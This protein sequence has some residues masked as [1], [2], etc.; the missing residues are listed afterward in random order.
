MNY[1]KGWFFFDF[2]TSLPYQIAYGII[3]TVLPKILDKGLG[4]M[5]IIPKFYRL[6]RI[7]RLYTIQSSFSSIL[8][9]KMQ[10]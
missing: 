7:I 3:N 8:V 9:R 4:R 1:F 5:L 10:F 6:L 2:V